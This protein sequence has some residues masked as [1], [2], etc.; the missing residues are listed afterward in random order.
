MKIR[1][2]YKNS[3]KVAFACDDNYLNY[4]GVAIFSIIE[5]NYKNN[6][7]EIYILHSSITL[8]KQQFFL[9]IFKYKNI[10]I[11]FLDVK[12][13]VYEAIL[14]YGELFQVYNHFT[15]ETYYRFFIPEIFFNFDRILYL[16]CDL[17]VCSDLSELYSLDTK[18]HALG[19]VREPLVSYFSKNNLETTFIDYIKRDL[20]I[21]KVYNYFQAGVLLYEVALCNKML[22]TEKCLMKLSEIKRTFIVDQDILNSVFCDKIYYLPMKWNV[23]WNLPIKYPL[24]YTKMDIFIL[25]EYIES[26]MQ[27]AI[28][29]YCD[30]F[31]PWSHPHLPKANIWWEHARG[32][33][34][35][36]EIIY[37]NLSKNQNASCNNL[38]YGAPE[39]IKQQLS[40]KIGKLFLK[41]NNIKGI[42]YLPF[43]LIYLYCSY[44]INILIYNKIVKIK[45]E[46]KMPPLENYEDYT[47]AIKV[48]QHLSYRLGQ[49]FLK[50]PIKF[51]FYSKKIYNEWK[52]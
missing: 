37:R 29:H 19:A 42:L 43:A 44:K 26:Y 12:E 40:Y 30:G 25:D 18:N 49:L 17:L 15:I 35:Y 5:Q 39:R 52:N 20:K 24:F 23:V 8:E 27:P 22:F 41:A 9:A 1:P 50:N 7:Y 2:Y 46:M 16:D 14:R 21:E 10:F 32:T 11:K 47:E 36:E 6:N 13:Y 48:K 45:P 4:L 3:I 34:F 33:P 51:I 28:L 31:K 38:Y